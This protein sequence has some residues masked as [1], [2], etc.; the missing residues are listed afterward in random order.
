MLKTG[1]RV[2]DTA[3]RAWKNNDIINLFGIPV[4]AVKGICK[5]SNLAKFARLVSCLQPLAKFALIAN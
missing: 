1:S 5:S 3:H 4:L 2:V